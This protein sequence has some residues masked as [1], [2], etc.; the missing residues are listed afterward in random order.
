MT[1]LYIDVTNAVQGLLQNVAGKLEGL[2]CPQLEEV[3]MDMYEVYP[4][5]GKAKGV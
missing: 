2:G 3:N 1:G 5:Y 4:G